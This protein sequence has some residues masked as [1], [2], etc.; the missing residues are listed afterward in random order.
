MSTAFDDA[1]VTGWEPLEGTFGLPDAE[2]E[3]VVVA[4]VVSGAV[5]IVTQNLKH[6]PAGKLPAPIRAIPARDFAYNTVRAHLA[7]SCRAITE[8][9]DRSGRH[10]PKITT[11][12][13]LTI[14]DERYQMPQAVELLSKAP[15][16]HEELN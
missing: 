7:Q 12:E 4:A 3:H 15:G 9:C 14:L 5:V 1:L 6:F 16:L 8:I 2:D 13:L 11:T 10:G